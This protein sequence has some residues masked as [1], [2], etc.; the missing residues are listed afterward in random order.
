ML[1]RSRGNV[2]RELRQYDAALTS[3]DRAIA[4]R[5]DF[6]EAYSNRGM[7]LH[8][9][10][11]P[12]EALESYDR[13]L[14]VRPDFIDALSNRGETLQELKRFDEAA[15]SYSRVLTLQP[16]HSIASSGIA[17]CAIKLCD[18]DLRA[19][20]ALTLPELISEQKSFAA[21]FVLLGYSNDPGQDRKST[22]LNS[23]HT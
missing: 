2:L 14:A 19:R 23:S 8:E 13:A 16:G 22:R 1:F 15:E 12:T 21:P 6:A 11:R 10:K 20:I 18:W 5:P 7:I 4:L 17:G 9:L 3:Y